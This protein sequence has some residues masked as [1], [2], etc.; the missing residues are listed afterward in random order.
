MNTCPHIESKKNGHD[1]HGQPRYRCLDCGKTWGI[2]NSEVGRIPLEKE[3]SIRRLLAEGV[4]VRETAR[5]VGVSSATVR[6]RRPRPAY[7]PPSTKTG[8]DL[9]DHC[10]ERIN[11]DREFFRRTSRLSHKFCDH[12]CFVAYFLHLR[13]RMECQGCGVKRDDVPNS[14]AWCRG[15]CPKCYSGL[16]LFGFDEAAARLCRLNVLLKKEIQNGQRLRNQKYV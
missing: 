12:D 13:G 11:K 5:R 8:H 14:K 6:A 16:R 3:A 9:C 7:K 15:Y 10:G 4:G 2:A 1:R